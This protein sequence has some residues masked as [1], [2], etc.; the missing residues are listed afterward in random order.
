MYTRV[1]DT[2]RVMFNIFIQRYFFESTSYFPSVA[3]LLTYID[4]VT[5]Q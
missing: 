1:S 4:C 3:T 5:L 2:S